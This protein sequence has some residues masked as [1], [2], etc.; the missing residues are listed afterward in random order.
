MNNPHLKARVL[1]KL[2][3]AP[4]RDNLR[5]ADNPGPITLVGVTLKWR[6]SSRST[7]PNS[8]DPP[9]GWPCG[10]NS[11]RREQRRSNTMS[12]QRLPPPFLSAIYRSHHDA[13]SLDTPMSCW[14]TAPLRPIGPCRERWDETDQGVKWDRPIRGL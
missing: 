13:G 7:K 14:P 5:V 8:K 1:L 9:A 10:T 3:T 2:P 12:G 4:F 11:R 6:I